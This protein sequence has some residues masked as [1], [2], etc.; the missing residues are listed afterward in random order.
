MAPGNPD[1]IVEIIERELGSTNFHD[2][3]RHIFRVRRDPDTGQTWTATHELIVRCAFNG[4]VTTNY[5]P[6]IVDARMAVRPAASSSFTSW[7][8]DDALDSWRTGDIFRERDL[9]ILYAHGHHNEPGDIIL[10]TTDY[11][12]A[13]AGKLRRVMERLFDQ[14]HLVWIGFSFADRQISAILN[15][16]VAGSGRLAA[17]GAAPRHV[18]ILPWDPA[19]D[20]EV[21]RDAITIQ[22][23]CRVVLYPVIDGSHRSCNLLLNELTE[24]RFPPPHWPP[25]PAK[26][27]LVSN[28]AEIATRWV[29]GGAVLDHFTGR[30][31]E[32]ARLDRWAADPDVRVIGVT[33]WG[34]AGKTSLVTEWLRRGGARSRRIK[35]VFAW[36]FYDDRSVDDWAKAVV[37]WAVETFGLRKPEGPLGRRLVEVVRAVPMMLLLDGLE[38]VQEGPSG[39]DFGRLFDGI[40]RDALIQLCQF[41]DGLVL[42]T[43]RFPFA[44]LARFYG[45]A[46]RTLD[47][48]PFTPA[49]GAV[50]LDRA[51]G[52]WLPLEERCDLVRAVDGHALAV[53]VLAAALAGRPPTAEVTDLQATLMAETRTDDRVRKVLSFYADRLAESDRILVAIV[54]LFTRPVPVGTVLLLGRNEKLGV[55]L[56]GWTAARVRETCRVLAGLLT[57]H[58]DET[59]SAHPLVRDAFRRLI[60]SGDTASLTSN[61]SLADLP[62]GSVR[63]RDEA[64]RVAEMVELLVEGDEWGAADELFRS[65]TGDGAV[66]LTLPA[67]R[68]GWRC[69]HTFIA[70]PNREARCR[71]AL[72]EHRLGSYMIGVGFLALLSGEPEVA[73]R[74][75]HRFLEAISVR[76]RATAD[77][78][79]HLAGCFIASGD[80]GRALVA[81]SRALHRTIATE[82]SQHFLGS[83]TRVAV[84][85][86]LRGDSLYAERWFLDADRSYYNEHGRHL[87][88]HAGVRWSEMLLRTGRCGVAR[89]L[90]K[91]NRALAERENW[92]QT[93]AECDHVLARCDLFDGRYDS[94]GSRIDSAVQQFRD[95]DMLVELASALVD[96]AEHKRSVR[97][98][99]EAERACGEA[100]VLA[101]PRNLVP[102]HARALAI[103]AKA[104]GDDGRVEQAR[105]DAEDAYRLA[106]GARRLPWQEL[107]ALEAHVY[108]D[109]IEGCDRGW[110]DRAR[111][112]Q[113]CL[114]PPGLY[115]D[116][117][118]T[119]EGTAKGTRGSE[120]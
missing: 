89:R 26:L 9:P 61:L 70:T 87:S 38:V 103:R 34:G 64:L 43:S 109:V 20:P 119:V 59:I 99:T 4:L 44:D 40:L 85:Y 78:L 79:G 113:L 73:I 104:R 76:D 5:D 15:E 31:G 41:G 1:P 35:G 6:G 45:T 58:P 25:P 92:Q 37:A 17:S 55:P 11:R 54:A 63:T 77:A 69:A 62:T 13:Y 8:S 106:T 120:S 2:V 91:L 105:D 102:A 115:R 33:A 66:F 50:L 21:V 57:W 75:L 46:V 67:V 107:D 95:G 108:L 97:D 49:E 14:D 82:D 19:L 101:A 52:Y 100:I 3:L 68:L 114:V 32:L 111:E 96:L 81:A 29:H 116:P 16:V 47:V 98:W 12:R 94:A 27:T 48:P 36:S 7:T 112:L 39:T 42:L 53:G 93:I 88:S 65:R 51:G 60:L 84:A 118:A 71:K 110:G 80:G 30:A 83:H 23:G 72:S 86:D 117:L 28:S 18:A 74:S 10:A 90:A 22:Y 24:D 56:A